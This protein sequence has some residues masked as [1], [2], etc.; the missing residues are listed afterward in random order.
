MTLDYDDAADVLYITFHV[1]SAPCRYIEGQT[2]AVLR[3][4]PASGEIVG[5]T[6]PFFSRLAKGGDFTVP[7]IPSLPAISS[8]RVTQNDPTHHRK[9]RTA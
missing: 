4:D 7:E 2:G 6:I 1:T 9:A 8:L 5:C 3:V